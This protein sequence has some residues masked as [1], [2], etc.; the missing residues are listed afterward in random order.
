MSL[1]VFVV[2]NV[3]TV[4]SNGMK[5]VAWFLGIFQKPEALKKDLFYCFC[6]KDFLSKRWIHRLYFCTH[7]I[8]GFY[9]VPFFVGGINRNRYQIFWGEGLWCWR[10]GSSF[11]PDL[12]E[13]WKR[14]CSKAPQKGGRGRNFNQFQ[15]FEHD[16]I[17]IDFMVKG[18][19]WSLVDMGDTVE[20]AFSEVWAELY[21]PEKIYLKKTYSGGKD[22]QLAVWACLRC[23]FPKFSMVEGCSNFQV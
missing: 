12:Q 7:F 1:V 23:R 2:R 9:M 10:M 8:N 3:G 14:S 16:M 5:M 4:D 13:L 17:S 20:G 6:L 21:R 22:P 19:T 18:T 15:P 11:W